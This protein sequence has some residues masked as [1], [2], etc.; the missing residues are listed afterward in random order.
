LN[1]QDPQSIR[2]LFS[3]I[4]RRYD[5]ANRLL[6]GGMDVFWRRRVGKIV[7][8]WN[9]GLIL[10]L[11]TGSGDLALELQ[12]CCPQATVV[13]A[14]FCLPMLKEAQR[15]KVPLLVNADGM[16][17]PF[18]DDAFSV[19]TVAFGLRNMASCPGAVS[20][21]R[22]VLQPGGHLLAL[23]FSL[24]E[25]PLRGPYRWYLH[26]VLPRIAG[27]LTGEMA[28]YTYLGDSIEQFPRGEGMRALFTECGLQEATALPLTGGIVSIYTG[29]K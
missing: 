1:H 18:A 23:D 9:P 29:R 25:P 13:G 6:S 20:E 11:A 21:M 5:L 3:S 10:D 8:T 15:K 22:R 26:H 27:M 14:D 28:A 12:R 7:R 19:V 4:A 24:P 16:K 2:K 17:L